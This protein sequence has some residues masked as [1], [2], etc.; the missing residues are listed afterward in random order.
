MRHSFT[1]AHLRL[2]YGRNSF[3]TRKCSRQSIYWRENI[4]IFLIANQPR[5][6]S[7]GKPNCSHKSGHLNVHCWSIYCSSI[8]HQRVIR[9]GCLTNNEQ[10]QPN[11][12]HVSNNLHLNLGNVSK[13]A[14]ETEKWFIGKETTIYKQQSFFFSASLCNLF[15]RLSLPFLAMSNL[16]SLA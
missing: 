5:R 1:S 2:M 14:R 10:S 11:L 13:L 12:I 6:L 4:Q 9:T 16:Y 3:T 15:W 7:F 8:H